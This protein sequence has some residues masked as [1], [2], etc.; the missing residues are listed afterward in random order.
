MLNDEQ[1]LAP[2]FL[3]AWNLLHH[4]FQQ[5]GN[6]QGGDDVEQQSRVVVTLA[7]DGDKHLAQYR[8]DDEESRGDGAQP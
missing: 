7:R 2:H 8:M 1:V 4:F 3:W 5:P 6:T